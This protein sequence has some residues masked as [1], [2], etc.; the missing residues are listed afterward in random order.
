ME[1]KQ[2]YK[3]TEIGIIPEDWEVLSLNKIATS[4]CSGKSLQAEKNGIYPLYGSTGMIGYRSNPDY[5]G[6][7]ILIARVGANAG[8]VY[9]VSNKYC[10]SD[11]TLMI[12]LSSQVNFEFV[13]FYLKHL[14]LNRLV[15]GSGQPLITGTQ[16]KHL[17]IN[18]PPLLEQQAI[19]TALSDV[20]DLISSLTRLI[21]KKKN[22][23][24]GTMQELLTG[25]KRL[26][27]FNEEW[28]RVTIKDL[29][30]LEPGEITKGGNFNYLEIGDININNK[31][32]YILDKKKLSVPGSV[33]VPQGILLI[34]T[35][36]PTR[37]AITITKETIYVSSA[38]CRLKIENMF[39]F[40]IVTHSQFLNYLGENSTGGT[41]PTCK[42][43]Y[44]ELQI[45]NT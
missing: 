27:G 7:K 2:G 13:Y 8:S 16:L 14:K 37:G 43:R 39:L 33:K 22:I 1:I 31:N 34:S 3:K 26:P 40:H 10:V 12:Q 19:A 38:F 41:Y 25:K 35:V 11:N 42:R 9:Y 30:Q 45:F 21:E 29:C 23:K 20:D 32:Y 17:Q 5:E 4:V 15:F 36:R 28:E 44:I 6:M 18:I 24:Q